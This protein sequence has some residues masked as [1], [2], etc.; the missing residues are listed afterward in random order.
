M[1]T[2]VYD[3]IKNSSYSK[4]MIQRNKNSELFGEEFLNARVGYFVVTFV[5]Q[6]GSG[7]NNGG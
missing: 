4:E 7:E 1:C 6:T 5:V 3:V 2:E